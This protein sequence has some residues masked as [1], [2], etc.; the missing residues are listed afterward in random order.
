MPGYESLPGAHGNF[1]VRVLGGF[2]LFWEGSLLRV[3]RASQRLLAF[4][5]LQ[6]RMVKRAAIAG[7]LW[8]EASESRASANLRSALAR[9]QGPARKSLAANK[10]ELGLAED[11]GVDVRDAQGLARRLLDP[12]ATPDR[13]E[14]GLAAVPVLSADLLPD[15]YDDWVLL[16]AEDWRQLRLHALEALA[17]RLIALGRWGEAANAAGAAVR[18]E[19]L[20]ESARAALIQAHLAEGNQSE[21]V[22]EFTRYRTLLDAELGLAPTPRLHELLASLHSPSRCDHCHGVTIGT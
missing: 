12:A 21:A 8:P 5:A 4:L 20:R 18:A 22:R 15:W 19:P 16:E 9:L 1:M 11:I 14:L 10:L 7:T 17:V 6:S 3:P 2:A 13:A